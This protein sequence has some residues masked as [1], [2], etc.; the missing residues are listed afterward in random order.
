[1]IGPNPLMNKPPLKETKFKPRNYER[2]MADNLKIINK[3][4]EPVPFQANESREL[5][6][7]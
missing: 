6:K 4:K 2:F 5:S 7:P 3:D 1:M